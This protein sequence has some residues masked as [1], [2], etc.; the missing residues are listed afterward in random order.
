MEERRLWPASVPSPVKKIV[1]EPVY[2]PEIPLE[3]VELPPT[4]VEALVVEEPVAVEETV[5]VT[6]TKVFVSSDKPLAVEKTFHQ[7]SK[8]DKKHKK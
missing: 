4:L 7:P 8:K 2:T 5:T 1:P 6:E 3:M